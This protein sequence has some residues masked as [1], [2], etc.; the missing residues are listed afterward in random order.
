M[1][2]LVSSAVRNGLDP[3]LYLRDVLTR[4]AALRDSAEGISRENLL[5]LL[6]N[7]WQPAAGG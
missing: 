2:T 3:W 7:R 1:F 4:L 6:P 5:P